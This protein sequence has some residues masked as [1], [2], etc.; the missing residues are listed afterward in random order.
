MCCWW[1]DAATGERFNIEAISSYALAHQ[2]YPAN[3]TL[4]EILASQVVESSDRYPWSVVYKV[5]S[6]LTG[7]SVKS[8]RSDA[9]QKGP[10]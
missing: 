6:R 9:E 10:S 7:K 4:Y 2:L 1:E 3:R 5:S 8:N